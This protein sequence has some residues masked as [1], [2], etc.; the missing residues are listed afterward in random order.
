MKFYYDCNDDKFVIQID[1]PVVKEI[2]NTVIE[3]IK[4]AYSI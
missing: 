1:D 2:V 3:R 4:N